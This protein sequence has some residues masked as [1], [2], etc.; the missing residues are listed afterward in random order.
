MRI[1]RVLAVLGMLGV[2]ALQATLTGGCASTRMGP[3]T[4]PGEV[5]RN[6]VEAERLSREAA[7]IATKEPVKAEKMLREALTLDLYCG[8]AHN[9][10]GVLYLKQGD[11]YNAA[12]E[13]EWAR[14]LL[15]GNPDPRMNLAFALERA[16]RIDEAISTYQTALEVRGEYV[17]AMQALA[18]LQLKSGKPGEKTNEYL[19]QIA[20]SGETAAWREWAKAWLLKRPR[21]KRVRPPKPRES[22]RARCAAS[23]R[24]LQP[25]AHSGNLVEHFL[26]TDSSRFSIAG[27]VADH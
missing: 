20:M 27:R 14:K 12:N 23:E 26:V 7:E 15:P 9:N 13:F 16:G 11:L 6:P 17:P 18:R 3:Y 19:R 5:A 10:L 24:D 4:P 21:H 25:H 2:L 8:P 1:M 22:E